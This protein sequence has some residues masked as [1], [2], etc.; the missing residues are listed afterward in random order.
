MRP[1]R[2]VAAVGAIG[3]A[4]AVGWWARLERDARRRRRQPSDSPET[5]ERRETAAVLDTATDRAAHADR[6]RS[7]S[8]VTLGYAGSGG[9]STA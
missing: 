9:S 1:A 3:L 2:L 8:T 6:H 5:T 7:R 4:A